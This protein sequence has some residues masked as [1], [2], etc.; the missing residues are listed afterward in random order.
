MVEFCTSKHLVSK[1]KIFQKVKSHRKF[2]WLVNYGFPCFDCFYP[3]IRDEYYMVND[4]TW[5]AAIGKEHIRYLCIGCLEKRLKRKLTRLDFT[6]API[7]SM[8]GR[9]ERLQDCLLR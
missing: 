3:T 5:Q 1:N 9:S 2:E 8:P 7:N 6:S 4:I